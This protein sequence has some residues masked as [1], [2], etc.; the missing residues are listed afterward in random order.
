[1]FVRPIVL[2]LFAA[3]MCPAQICPPVGLFYV[4][5][6]GD[7]RV[8]SEEDLAVISRQLP[9][10]I[11]AAKTMTSTI[12]V[13][14]NGAYRLGRGNG[15]MD[16]P[17]LVFIN[18]YPCSMHLGDV[19]LMYQGKRMR[20]VFNIDFDQS[21]PARYLFVDSPPFQEGTFELAVGPWPSVD[22][23]TIT[24]DHWRKVSPPPIQ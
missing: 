17:V 22:F 6:G 18:E 8:L 2:V 4:V 20:L 12:S 7:G 5:R 16:V 23:T 13:G 15:T 11:G 1:M 9:A 10:T 21:R 14:A 19:T 24:A 3:V